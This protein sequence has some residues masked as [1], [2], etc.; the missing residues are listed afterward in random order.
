MILFVYAFI[1][2]PGVSAYSIVSNYCTGT[3]G[4]YSDDQRAVLLEF[5]EAFL[6][7]FARICIVSALL[8][9]TTICCVMFISVTAIQCFPATAV[10]SKD[11]GHFEG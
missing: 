8:H 1:S 7:G 9:G 11:T 10:K 6:P 5:A 3:G 4:D 2:I